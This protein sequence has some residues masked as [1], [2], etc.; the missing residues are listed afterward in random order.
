MSTRSISEL[1]NPLERTFLLSRQAEIAIP[2]IKYHHVITQI[3]S[4]DFELLHDDDV[5]FEYIEHSRESLRDTPWMV[6]KW[7]T[8]AIDIPGSE[9]HDDGGSRVNC[10]FTSRSNIVGC[11]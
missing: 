5:G 8:D 3:L 10:R 6:R 1:K 4:L 9:S 11:E 7:I 2:A